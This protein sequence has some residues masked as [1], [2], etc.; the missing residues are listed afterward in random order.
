M[1]RRLF[2]LAVA[3][4]LILAVGVHWGVLQ[5][6]AWAGMVITYAHSAPLTVA[7]QKTFDGAHPCKLCKVVQ[8][9]KNSENKHSSCKVETKLDFWL[10]R[11][12]AS[13]EVPPPNLIPPD[14]SDSAP[15]RADSPPTPPPR[16]A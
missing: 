3:G 16:V 9:G 10:V 8:E 2:Q 7:L 1:T 13:L 11:A 15:H 12:A 5:S 14:L 4:A 6:V